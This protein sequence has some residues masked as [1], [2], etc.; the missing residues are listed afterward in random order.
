M[1]PTEDAIAF[2]VYNFNIYSLFEA[3]N[4]IKIP[5]ILVTI[6]SPAVENI[7]KKY[8]KKNIDNKIYQIFPILYHTQIYFIKI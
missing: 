2:I 6:A 5:K 8:S 3:L 4:Q 7:S 1:F